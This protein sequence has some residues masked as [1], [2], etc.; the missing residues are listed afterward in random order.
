MALEDFKVK[1]AND[2]GVP[3]SYF[4][5]ESEEAVVSQALALIAYKKDQLKGIA[6]PVKKSTREQFAD[7]MGTVFGED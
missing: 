3:V 7:W 2:V 6:E 1:V 4:T 5:G